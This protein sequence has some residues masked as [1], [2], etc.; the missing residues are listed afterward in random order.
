[1]CS[2]T[3]ESVDEAARHVIQLGWGALLA[4]VD[5]KAAYR[6]VP[7]HLED[8]WLLG[9]QFEGA[10]YMDTVLPFGLRSAQKIFNA[11]A[12]ALQWVC[13]REGVH[14]SLHYL[15]HFLLNWVIMIT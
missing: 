1:M 2:L 9:M 15:N 4:K 11:M 10:T 6:L 12:E 3:Y 14:N 5:I 8:R 7:V 13:Q